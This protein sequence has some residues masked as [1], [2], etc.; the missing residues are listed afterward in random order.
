M[1]AEL[2]SE[3]LVV[4]KEKQ[5][6]LD[7]R[8]QKVRT[9]VEP[10]AEE[11]Y[12]YFIEKGLSDGLPIIPPTEERVERMLRYSLKDP[13]EILIQ[14]PNPRGA[15]ITVEKL[16]ISAVMAGCKPEYFP[17]L[18]AAIEAM[19]EPEFHLSE[20]HAATFPCSITI[21]FSGPLADEVGI[22]SDS[23]CLGPGFRANATI[24]RAVRLAMICILGIIPG[25]TDGATLGSPAKYSF[26][27]AENVKQSPWQPLHVDLYDSATTS[28]TV[29]CTEGPQNVVDHRHGTAED[30]LRAIAIASTSLAANNAYWP[31]SLLVALG[32]DH[33]RIVAASGF[34]K[35][36]I[37]WFIYE[38]ARNSLDDIKR[39][40]IV[41][42]ELNRPKSHYSSQGEMMPC[43]RNPEDVLVVTAG[44]SGPMSMIAR[45]WGLSF[46]VHR[47]VVL[48]GGNIA[49]RIA[50]FLR[51]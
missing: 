31:C 28:V 19:G 48:K 25:I 1:N 24:G 8:S 38:N 17:L 47:P 40:G 2:I 20:L 12:E 4:G 41:E 30:I 15:P 50:D 45:P 10:D 7:Q 13:G 27:F 11:I 6:D 29:L 9:L 51:E 34:T 3:R 18:V 16:A 23:G 43:V 35:D 46:A 14:I 33:A 36:D 42:I 21:V 26:C 5:I 22:R 49:Y 32:L 39:G 37:K 44:G